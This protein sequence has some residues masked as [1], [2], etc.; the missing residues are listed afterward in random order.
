VECEAAKL[1]CLIDYKAKFG[2]FATKDLTSEEEK[3]L[4]EA[5]QDLV[6]EFEMFHSPDELK[7]QPG[8]TEKAMKKIWEE[9]A[10]R[11]SVICLCEGMFISN[12]V[13]RHHGL[14]QGGWV[15]LVG[16]STWILKI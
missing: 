5:K 7:Y 4:E 12:T 10:L 16:S 3:E 15:L 2:K 1:Q 9:F 8:E 13:P 14:G 6:H 11:V